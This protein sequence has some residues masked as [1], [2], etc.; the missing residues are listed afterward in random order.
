MGFL[1]SPVLCNIFMEE[2][3]EKAISSY[4]TKTVSLEEIR[5][6]YIFCLT[7]Q[8]R[9]YPRLPNN[10]N[11]QDEDLNFTIE[12]QSEGRL[13]IPDGELTRSNDKPPDSPKYTVN[14]LTQIS[15]CNMTHYTQKV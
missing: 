11:S 12:L 1:L 3:E 14:Q 5:R 7:W 4:K 15:T 10:S 9:W 8:W 13:P 2:L 6:L